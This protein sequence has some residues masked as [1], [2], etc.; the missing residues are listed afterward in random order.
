MEANR[1]AV[2]PGNPH[3]LCVDGTPVFLIGAT[4]AYGWTPISRPH[5]DYRRDLSRLAAVIDRVASPHVRGLVRVAPYFPQLDGIQPWERGADGRYHLDRF[6][7]EWEG[8]LTEFLDG[9]QARGLV[10]SLELWEDWSITRGPGGAFDPGPDQGWNVHPFNPQHNANYGPDALPATTSLVDAPFYRTIPALLNSRH[11]LPLQQLYAER[12]CAL[13]GPYPNVIYSLSNES[14]APLE[15]SRYWAA[16]LRERLGPGKLIGDMP[17]TNRRDGRG[18][19]DPELNPLTLIAEDAYDYADVSQAV[20]QHE[21]GEEPFSQ[22]LQAG[23]RIAAYRATMEELGQTKPLVVS[24]DYTNFRPGGVPVLWSKFVGGAASARFHR[25]MPGADE[26]AVADFQF[27]AIG[28]LGEFVKLTR[29]YELAPERAL[30]A[31]VPRGMGF[32]SLGRPGQEHVLQLFGRTGGSLDL[33]LEAGAFRVSWYDPHT[34][35][36]LKRDEPVRRPV[37]YLCALPVPR[38]GRNIIGHLTTA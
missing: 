11:V 23:Q 37:G 7:P 2:F 29:F 22:A 10:V 9:A 25:P 6:N 32:L 20:S 1:V 13:S 26:E 35:K 3:Y 4:H 27:D 24:K 36:W 30:V 34:G 31:R 21:F 38:H 17:S 14:R 18:E 8:R 15:W 5:H 33:L 19:C 28:H 12:L 16:Y